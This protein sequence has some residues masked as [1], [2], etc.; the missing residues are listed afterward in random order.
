[1]LRGGISF[2]LLSSA[3]LHFWC[4]IRPGGTCFSS[5]RS[6]I[7]IPRTVHLSQTY[8][9]ANGEYTS[10]AIWPVPHGIRRVT[11]YISYARGLPGGY[12]S[13]RLMWG[14]GVEEVQETL[15]DS[16]SNFLL[17]SI[18]VSQDL[19]LQDLSGPAPQN[20]DPVSFTIYATIPGGTTTVRLLAA[21]KGI[22]GA[23]GIVS[24]TLT[25]SD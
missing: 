5:C 7:E 23:P 10:Q 2:F 12:A 11:F 14:N 4:S 25:A 16:E 1:M 24:I 22:P 3:S 21:E 17:T 13:F 6:S 15:I 9:P 18:D 8:L 19:F 20:S